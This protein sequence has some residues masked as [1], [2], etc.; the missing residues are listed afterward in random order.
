MVVTLT[1]L[2]S[3]EVVI[4][5]GL[6]VTMLIGVIVVGVGGRR[7]ADVSKRMKQSKARSS[8]T[9]TPNERCT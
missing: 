7:R 3:R 1:N 9:G 4:N 8:R 2:D 6:T 5:N